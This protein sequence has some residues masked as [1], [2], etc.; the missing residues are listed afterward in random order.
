MKGALPGHKILKVHVFHC[1]S[2]LGSDSIVALYS[3][4]IFRGTSL[5]PSQKQRPPLE[6][7]FFV[8]Y[9]GKI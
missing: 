2:R 9:V 8:D 1:Q 5:S 6:S 7:L 4:A 3:L